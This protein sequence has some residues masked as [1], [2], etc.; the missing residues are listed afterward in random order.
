[1]KFQKKQD[2]KTSGVRGQ[3]SGYLISGRDHRKRAQRGFEDFDVVL[4][5]DL[6]RVYTD[7]FVLC[8]VVEPYI[9]DVC[10]SLYTFCA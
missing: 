7:V 10:T 8:R 5:L 4:F 3:G 9:C 6:K 2:K 1:M